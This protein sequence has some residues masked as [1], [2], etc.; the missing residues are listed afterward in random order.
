MRLCDKPAPKIAR[1]LEAL[2][3]RPHTSRELELPPVFDHVAHSTAADLRSLGVELTTERIA[4]PGFGGQP[5][6]VARYS[7]SEAAKP[8]ARAVLEQ[9]LDRRRAKGAA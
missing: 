6:H 8:R 5:A 1:V 4:I 2:L 7:I 3:Q 9:I